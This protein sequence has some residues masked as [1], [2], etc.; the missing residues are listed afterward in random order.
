MAGRDAPA[1]LQ[2]V[3]ESGSVWNFVSVRAFASPRASSA[4]R[5]SF[6]P[7]PDASGNVDEP[8]SFAPG[9]AIPN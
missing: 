7:F 5:V 8:F 6:G 4:C 2:G 3:S 1:S 9:V